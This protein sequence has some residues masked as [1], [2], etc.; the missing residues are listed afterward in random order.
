MDFDEHTETYHGTVAGILNEDI[1]MLTALQKSISSW[2][3]DSIAI[4]KLEAG[5]HAS[6]N[7]LIDQIFND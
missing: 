3:F 4:I 7:H 2:R 6:I 5:L 1:E